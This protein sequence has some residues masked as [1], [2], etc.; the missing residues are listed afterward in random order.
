M[1]ARTAS[2][3]PERRLLVLLNRKASRA[4]QLMGETLASLATG[5]LALDIRCPADVGALRAMIEQEGPAADAVVIAG[6]DGT[7]SGALPA[8]LVLGRPVGILPVGTAN[9]LALTLGIPADPVAAAEVIAGDRRRRIDVGRANQSH[10]VNVASIG[11]SV[12]IAERHT[13]EAKRQW[14]VLSYAITALQTLG[15]AERFHATITCDGHRTEL[16]TYQIAVGNG[17]HYGG[18]MKVAPGAAIDDGLLDAYAVETNSVRDL[19]AL[20]PLLP[21]G[22]L[23]DSKDVHAFRGHRVTVE[24]RRPMPVNTDGEVTTTTPV[25]FS[26]ERA[27]LEIFVPGPGNLRRGRRRAAGNR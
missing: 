20:A 17:V 26:V 16:L 18:G 2:R 14:G 24:T 6:G 5:G 13:P 15:A 10:F 12:K 7:L 11:L 3:H 9:D 25:E 19:L 23:G 1:S 22:N 8:L 4:R 21:S 27:A